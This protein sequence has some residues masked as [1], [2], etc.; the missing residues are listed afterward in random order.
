MIV[1]VVTYNGEKE[2]LEIRLNIL[3]DVVD[4]FIIVEA[5]TTFTGKWKPLY[6]RRHEPKFKKW[7][8]KI[9]YYVIKENYTFE[10]KALAENSPNTQGAEHWKHEFLQKE[11][12][13]RAMKHLDDDDIVFIGDVDEIWDDSLLP[14]QH[15]IVSKLKL[16]VYT[17]YLNLKSSEDFHGTITGFYKDIKDECLNH[18]RVNANKT[19]GYCGWHFTSQGG[20]KEV[21]RK[22]ESSYTEDS[23]YTKEVQDS[24]E[25]RF[26]KEDFLGRGFKLEVDESE[27]P[28]WL[29]ENKDRY[30]KLWMT[31][32]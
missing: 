24:L 17:Y 20:L 25:S 29:L 13:K 27:L 32:K 21:K 10:E 23:Y 14:R 1:D 12:I 5:P 11:R 30:K 18:L 9:R 6:Y 7:A 4:Q 26:G 8:H 31:E 3:G 28:K 16:R 2:L 15:G 22:L 19:F